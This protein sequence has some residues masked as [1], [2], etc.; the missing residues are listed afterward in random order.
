MIHLSTARTLLLKADHIIVDTCMLMKTDRIGPFL[1]KHGTWMEENNVQIHVPKKVCLELLKHL[2]SP[3]KRVRDEAQAAMELIAEYKD[4]GILVADISPE[5]APRE[6][7]FEDPFADNHILSELMSSYPG[8]LQV[9]I[10][11]DKALKDDALELNGMKSCKGGKIKV[12]RFT[13][14]G[15]IEI[16][17]QKKKIKRETIR[18][19]TVMVFDQ[20]DESAPSEAP[21]GA[22][23]PVAPEA[24]KARVWQEA[25]VGSVTRPVKKRRISCDHFLIFGSAAAGY[26]LAVKKPELRKLGKE[27]IKLMKRMFKEFA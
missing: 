20:P 18:C 2:E 5:N 14:N 9:L 15:E 23:E 10:T 13:A 12:M 11:D 4:R 25:K 22:A 7:E 6:D 26:G 21:A 19:K 16:F 24:P 17:S 8:K 1:Q 3:E 27:C